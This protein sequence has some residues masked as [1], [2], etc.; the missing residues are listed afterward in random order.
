MLNSCMNFL[1]AL[2]G[3]ALSVVAIMLVVFVLFKILEEMGLVK[4]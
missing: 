1:L 3:D 2:E 4:I